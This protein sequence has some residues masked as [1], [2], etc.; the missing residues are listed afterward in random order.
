MGNDNGHGNHQATNFQTAA[1][2]DAW[3][4]QFYPERELLESDQ[5]FPMFLVRGGELV[6]MP[7][8]VIFFPKADPEASDVGR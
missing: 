1:D 8:K 2:R 6:V 5:P 7:K 4:S 3:L